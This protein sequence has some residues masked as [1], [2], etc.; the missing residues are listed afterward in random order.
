MANEFS[1]DVEIARSQFSTQMRLHKAQ[2]YA[3]DNFTFLAACMERLSLTSN[4]LLENLIAD[5]MQRRFGRTK[6]GRVGWLPPVAEMGDFI[7]IFDGMEL[8]YVIRPAAHGRYLLVG[9]CLIPGIMMGEAFSGLPGV[10]SEII[11]LE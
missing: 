9:E 11:V 7:C 1:Q 8:P 4:L 5:K 10:G 6:E 2:A 3:V